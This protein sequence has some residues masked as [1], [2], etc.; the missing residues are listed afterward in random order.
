V[1][2]YILTFLAGR[3]ASVSADGGVGD[4]ET[5][6]LHVGQVQAHV[7]PDKV[8]LTACLVSVSSLAFFLRRALAIL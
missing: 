3:V 6:S 8:L 2:N 1:L 4:A 5:T 7:D